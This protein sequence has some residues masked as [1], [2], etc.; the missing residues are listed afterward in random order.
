MDTPGML[1]LFL[2]PG[3]YYNSSHLSV[4]HFCPEHISKSIRG[5]NFK[6]HRWI[7]LMGEECNAQERLFYLSHIF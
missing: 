6:L 3:G 4:P 1:D 2:T 5:I 7:D